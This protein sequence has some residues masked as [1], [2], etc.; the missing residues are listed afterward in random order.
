MWSLPRTL[1]LS[2]SRTPLGNEALRR[3]PLR[4]KASVQ[5]GS[6]RSPGREKE[7]AHLTPHDDLQYYFKSHA[8]PEPE[9]TT[10]GDGEGKGF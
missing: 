3:A 6:G 2:F 1:S 7:G 10:T 4:L 8:P 9:N 5:G